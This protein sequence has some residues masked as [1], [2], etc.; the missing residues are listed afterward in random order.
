MN[1]KEL[2]EHLGL[3]QTTISRALDGYPEVAETTRKRVQAA[4]KRYAYYPNV[5]A[6]RLA[7]GRAGAAGIVFSGNKNLLAEPHYTAFLAGLS[8]YLS[9][10]D[11]DIL[12]RVASPDEEERVYRQMVDTRRVDI[13]VISSPY[14][15]DRRI[16]LLHELDVPFVVHGRTRSALAYSYLDIDNYRG[17]YDATTVFI[18][19][20]H[21]RIGLINGEIRFTFA[22]D[23]Q[24][25]WKAALAAKGIAIDDRLH[26]SIVM[27]EENGYQA[28]RELLA[29]TPPPSAFLCTDTLTTYG[30]YRALA[31]CDLKVGSDV[32]VIAHDDR[33]PLIRPE[34][35]IPS[36]STTTSAIED[37]GRRIAQMALQLVKSGTQGKTQAPIQE[38]W[39]PTMVLRQSVAPYKV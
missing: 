3:S 1:L 6:R 7:T 11:M 36:L 15:T 16:A 35:M 39:Q 13:F 31:E 24:A 5:S 34:T 2:S 21:R 30:V 27:T 8:D 4:A 28:A 19:H 17:F 32:S 23:R 10:H 33:L 14:V 22:H 37:H 29:L 38:V 12:F 9:Q 26:R 20:G 18:A 25:G